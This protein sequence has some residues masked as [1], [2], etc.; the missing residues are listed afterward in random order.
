MI[1][2]QTLLLTLPSVVRGEACEELRDFAE[3]SGA[4]AARGTW[5]G[6]AMPLSR[7]ASWQLLCSSLAV[8]YRDE[9]ERR[10]NWSWP[11]TLHHEVP[12]F[13]QNVDLK[14]SKN[15]PKFAQKDIINEKV[16]DN[17]IVLLFWEPDLSYTAF[18]VLWLGM[19]SSV[20]L[21]ICFSSVT[22]LYCL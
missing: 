14:E 2:T 5:R 7:P 12:P 6:V 16:S 19:C 21:D 10:E 22:Q 17:E 18:H 15:G 8:S 1:K 11:P 20:K 3:D 13:C 4:S 9:A